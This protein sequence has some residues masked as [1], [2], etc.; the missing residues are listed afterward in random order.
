MKGDF[1]CRAVHGILNTCQDEQVCGKGCPCFGGMKEDGIPICRYDGE[2]MVENVFEN[3]GE[4]WIKKDKA[5]KE[6]ILPLFPFVNSLDDNLQKAYDFGAKAHEKQVRKGTTIPY[7]THIITAMNYAMT[8]TPNQDI[9]IAVL[10]HDTVEDTDVTLKDIE[11]EFG[12]VVAGFIASESEDKRPGIPA[13]DTWEIRKRETIQHLQTASYES[14]L[15]TLADKAANAE[16]LL[17]EWRY[18]GDAMWEKFNQSDKKKQAWYYFSCA[19]ALEEFS[20]SEVM[21]SYLKHLEELFGEK[22]IFV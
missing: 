6:G 4:W 8:M 3:P 18:K 11:Q 14:K 16:A 21:R 17:R 10:L 5:I 7:F 1:Y 15:I 2:E 13:K 20:D 9:L 22:K 19:D 12:L